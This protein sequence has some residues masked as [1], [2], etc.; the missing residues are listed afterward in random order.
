MRE[1]YKG[2]LEFCMHVLHT[3]SRYLDIFSDPYAN[4]DFMLLSTCII[5]MAFRWCLWLCYCKCNYN[6]Y[7]YCQHI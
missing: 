5:P 6:Q 1:L 4:F 2:I 7:Y 3:V